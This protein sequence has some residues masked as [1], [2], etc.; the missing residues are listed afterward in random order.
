M[1]NIQSN[2][3]FHPC[4]DAEEQASGAKKYRS[5]ARQSVDAHYLSADQLTSGGVDLEMSD[6]GETN[7]SILP[8]EGAA[9][10][11]PK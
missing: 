6:N 10:Y 1:V 3:L 7:T 9:V 4:V 5:S 8:N 2:N 11:F